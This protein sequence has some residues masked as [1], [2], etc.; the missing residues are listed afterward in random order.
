M[1]EWW[2]RGRVYWY[3]ILLH[4]VRSGFEPSGGVEG[5]GV[6]AEEFFASVDDPLVDAELGLLLIS[7]DS[8]QFNLGKNSHQVRRTFLQLSVPP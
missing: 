4:R 7:S 1:V 2:G 8:P 6:F 5:V 3:V